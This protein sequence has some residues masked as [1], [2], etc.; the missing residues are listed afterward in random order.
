LNF[1]QYL[2]A[3]ANL[4]LNPF[5]VENC[6]T[7]ITVFIFYYKTKKQLAFEFIFELKIVKRS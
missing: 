1:N 3:L 6:G 5:C 4:S 7:E 2:L